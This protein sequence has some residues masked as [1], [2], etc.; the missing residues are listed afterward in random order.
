MTDLE[1]VETVLFSRDGE[2]RL[3]IFMQDWRLR[4]IL[5]EV[6]ALDGVPQLPEFHP[7]GDVLT[8]TLLAVRHLPPAPDRRLAW[9]VP[10]MMWARR[11]P[12]AK[13]KGGFAPSTTIAP[14]RRLQAP[15]WSGWVWRGT[16][17]S[18]SSG[19]FPTTCSL[20]LAGRPSWSIEPQAEEI[21]R[22]SPLPPPPQPPR[23][24]CPCR[25][26]PP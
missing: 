5:P 4:Q 25:R 9:A 14:A 15:S 6:Y 17:P 18:I 24:R 19:S 12:P 2:E 7:E 20:E 11:Q 8:H 23:N 22:G 16:S 3:R 10:S 26:F 21:H 13:W 1:T